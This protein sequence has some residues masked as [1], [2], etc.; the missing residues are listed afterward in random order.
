M[1]IL[2]IGTAYSYFSS[3]MAINRMQ[4]EMVER[5]T[6]IEEQANDYLTATTEEL[7]RFSTKGLNWAVRGELIR[8]N[9]EQ[10]QQYITQL[11]KEDRIQQ[12]EFITPDGI[13]QMSSDKK[14]EGTAFDSSVLESDPLHSET[15]EYFWQEDGSVKLFAPIL[16]LEQKLGTLSIIYTADSFAFYADSTAVSSL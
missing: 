9:E 12:V 1:G 13:I 16:G 11:V 3:Q 4:E 15:P 6:E 10:V 5:Q 8:G 7:L 14:R 2:A